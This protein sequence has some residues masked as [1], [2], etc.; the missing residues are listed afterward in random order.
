MSDEN[1]AV[2]AR[3][4]EVY[5]TGNYDIIDEVTSSDYV[6]HDPALPEPMRGREALKAQAAGYRAAFSDLRITVDQQ[7][8]EGEYVVTRWTGRGTHDGELFG[9]SPT[10][11]S[12]E[13]TGISIARIVDGKIVEDRTEWNALGLMQQV[14]AIPAM[15]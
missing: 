8:A 2:A 13:A 7:I 1:K 4:F 5:S 14:G 9:I 6:G 15:A 3:G 11:K 12:V 10:G